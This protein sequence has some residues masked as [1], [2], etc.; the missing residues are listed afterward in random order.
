MIYEWRLAL[1]ILAVAPLIGAGSVMEMMSMKGFAKRNQSATAFANQ[2][3]TECISNI[4]TVEAF[5]N[6]EKVI[7]IFTQR[8]AGPMKLGTMCSACSF[9][10]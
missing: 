8:L 5:T 4:R 6:E 2:I 1:V 7:D 3:A 10:C 9:M